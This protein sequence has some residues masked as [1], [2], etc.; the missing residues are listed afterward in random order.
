MPSCL[1]NAKKQDFAVEQLDRRIEILA[2]VQGQQEGW[3]TRAV[4]PRQMSFHQSRTPVA[5]NSTKKCTTYP[6]YLLRTH[7]K[8][9]AKSTLGLR[10]LRLKI[11]IIILSGVEVTTFLLVPSATAVPIMDGISNGHRKETA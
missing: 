2:S 3:T 4:C 7:L 9:A 5:D 6:K 11:G 10:A 1:Q 8:R